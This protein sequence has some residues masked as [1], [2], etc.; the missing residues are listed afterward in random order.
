MALAVTART[1]MHRYEFATKENNGLLIDLT[2][3]DEV[4][5]SWIEVVATIPVYVATGVRK[6]GLQIS[7]FISL[8]FLI[9]QFQSIRSIITIP[10]IR[11]NMP[12][13]KK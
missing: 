8:L 6:H 2:H 3:R 4:L 7:N 11:K 10:F 1:G 13:E 12:K 9:S 5:N